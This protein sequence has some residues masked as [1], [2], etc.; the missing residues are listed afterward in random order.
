MTLRPQVISKVKVLTSLI[1]PAGQRNAALIGTAIWGP[2]NQV[3]NISTLSEYVSYFGDDKSGVGVTGIKAADLFFRNGGT[4]KVVRVADGTEAK[5][6]HNGQNGST[7]VINFYAKYY[8]T[9]GNNIYITIKTN[10]I[11]TSNRDIEITDGTNIETFTNAGQGYSTNEDIVSA[12]NSSSSLVTAVVVSGHETTDLVDAI[13]KTQFT[14]GA[15]GESNV[16]ITQITDAFDNNLLQEEF[17]FLLVPGFTD[18]SDITTITSKLDTRASSEKIYSRFITGIAKDETISTASGRTTQSMRATIVAPNVKYTSR[19]DGSE[20]ILD[21]SYLACAYAGK[22]CALDLEISGT[23]ETVSVDGVSVLESSGKE[24]YTKAEQE[25]LLQIGIAPI[26]RI[27]SSIQMVR[28]ITRVGDSTDVFFEEVVVDITDFVKSQLEAYLNTKLG[29][30]NTQIN[31]SIYATELNARL[32]NFVTQGIL[33][34]YTEAVV[35]EGSSPDSM[36]VNV[37][38]KPAYSTNFIYL[39]LNIN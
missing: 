29:K 1:A 11:N 5:S 7:D 18:D 22:L 21:G 34:D 9:Y 28:G 2:I 35:I 3:V 19:V 26:T 20:V 30:P 37:G 24:Y 36:I 14:G 33:E 10:A 4:L 8:G 17:N 25:Q 12:I 38:V 23:H 16:T 32:T 39:T 31:R 15:D 6:T 27:G 13:P